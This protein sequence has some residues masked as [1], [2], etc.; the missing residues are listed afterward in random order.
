MHTNEHRDKVYGVQLGLET[1][2]ANLGGSSL[3]GNSLQAANIQGRKQ[4]TLSKS[5]LAPEEGFAMLVGL[6]PKGFAFPPWI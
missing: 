3:Q 2:L 5:T 4:H 1:R 6:I